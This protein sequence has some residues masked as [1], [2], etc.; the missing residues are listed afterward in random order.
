MAKCWDSL[1]P[2]SH[3][4]WKMV[5]LTS[6]DCVC[7]GVTQAMNCP[8]WKFCLW[9]TMVLTVQSNL[10][11]KSTK[12]RWPRCHAFFVSLHSWMTFQK[13]LSPLLQLWNNV[14]EDLPPDRF[15]TKKQIGTQTQHSEPIMSSMFCIP[16]CLH[17]EV[18]ETFTGRWMVHHEQ[19]SSQLISFLFCALSFL[20]LLKTSTWK[21]TIVLQ[22]SLSQWTFDHWRLDWMTQF[23]SDSRFINLDHANHQFTKSS[24]RWLV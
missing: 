14:L 5:L 24:K 3:W 4:M 18:W 12:L 9:W 13:Y 15:V 11:N 2:S 8:L 23:H 6:R 20:F 21:E 19:T 17:L 22:T 7:C 1:Q 16:P 10:L